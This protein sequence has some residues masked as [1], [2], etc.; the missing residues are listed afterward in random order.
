MRFR[1]M[2]PTC[3]HDWSIDGRV[4]RVNKAAAI[5]PRFWQAKRFFGERRGAVAV[6][7][8]IVA[9]AFFSLLAA[10]FEVALIALGNQL[11]ITGTQEVARQAQLGTISNDATGEADV[12]EAICGASLGL[13]D[14]ANLRLR[15]TTFDNF[16]D[17]SV[18]LSEDLPDDLSDYEA[19][20]A[21]EPDEIVVFRVLYEWP[22][23]LYLP[24]ADRDNGTFLMIST[25]VIR[26]EPNPGG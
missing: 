8:A 10:L 18:T 13:F 19:F 22:V 11:L 6:E 9:M 24:M 15:V 4:G 23:L 26:N 17:A 16:A 7:F 12:R 2:S 20:D 21:G 14:C 3:R 25:T 5:A 1:Q